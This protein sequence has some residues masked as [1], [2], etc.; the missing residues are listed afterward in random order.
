[1]KTALLPVPGICQ[2]CRGIKESSKAKYLVLFPLTFV[3]TTIWIHNL[4]FS[5][6]LTVQN[7]SHIGCLTFW[8]I[9]LSNLNQIFSILTTGKV[10]NVRFWVFWFLGLFLDDFITFLIFIDL[11]IFIKWFLNVLV[12][13]FFFD[14][15]NYWIDVTI[16]HPW[17]PIAFCH[18][19]RILYK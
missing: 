3:V 6:L 13:W 7:L 18:S 19:T 15:Q 12:I 2:F 10:H 14:F 9:N 1:M 11:I 4:S 17:S 16:P 5:V 8:V